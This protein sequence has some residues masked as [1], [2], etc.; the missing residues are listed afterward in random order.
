MISALAPVALA[1]SLLAPPAAPAA[2][3]GA[4]TTG[5]GRDLDAERAEAALAALARDRG[6][7]A[8][9]ALRELDEV[10]EALPDRAQV[11][12]ALAAVAADP[13]ADPE[14]RALARWQQAGHE[15]A[16]GN[17]NKAA[18]LVGRMGFVTRWAVAGPFDDEG[19]RGH[20][21]AYPPEKGLDPAATMAG[22]V[23]E[24]RWRPLAPEAVVDGSVV[25]GAAL[26]PDAEV[27]A[28]ALAVVDAPRELEARLWWGG[29]G[30]ARVWVNGAPVL[31]DA[32]DHPQ[33]LDQRGAVV[34]LAAGPNRI[35]VKQAH[36]PGTWAFSLRLAAAAGEGLPLTV[37]DPAAVLA[38]PPPLPPGPRPAAR[39]IA[40]LV[41]R[42]AAAAEAA[43]RAPGGPGSPARRAEAEARHALAAAMAVRQPFDLQEHRPAREARRATALAPA[44]VEA[45]L[46]AAGLEEERNQRLEHLRAALAAEPANPRVLR[47]LAQIALALDRPQE[48]VRLMEPVV[49]AAPGWVAA[50]LTLATAREAAGQGARATAERL[51]LAE[52]TPATNPAAAA[53]A[54][55]ARRLGRTARAADLYRTALALQVDDG[56]TRGSLASLLLAT[57]DLAGSV[58]LATEALRLDPADQGTR[59]RLAD[60]LAANGRAE[61]A[62][63]AFADALRLCP[64][65]ADAWERRGRV[66]L[67]AGRQAEALADLERALELKPQSPALKELVRSL[68]PRRERYEA[69]YLQDAAALAAA[70]VQAGPEDDL[71]TLSDLE[72]VR[73]QR[74][75]LASRYSQRIVKVLTQRGA[76]A[77]RRQSVGY[78]P[79][80]QEVKVERGRI[81]KPDG[82]AVEAW[83]ESE[84]SASEPWYR[85]YYDTRAK[86]L[87][88]PALAPGDVLE[89]AWRV[90]DTAAENLLS[91]YFGDLAFV[92][93]GEPKRRWDYV[94][95]MPPGRAIHANAPPGLARTDRDLPDGTTEHRWVARD[96]PRLDG[97]PRM[98]GWAEV[99]RFLHVSTY[100]S[101]EEIN[102]FYWGLVQDQLRPTEEVRATARRVAAEALKARGQDPA[103]LEK[104]G[105][106]LDRDTQL[107]L[108]AAMHAFVVTQ[109]RYVG[110]EFGIHGFKPY[111]VDQ[112]LSR[113][114][115]DCKDKASLTHALLESIGIDSRLVLL[116]MRRLGRLPEQPASLAVFNHAILHLPQFGLWLDGTASYTGTREIPGEDR[117]ATVLVVDPGGKPWFGRIG[118][119]GPEENLVETRFEVALAADGAARVEGKS[120][121]A[122]V[123]ASSYRR[124]YQTEN[125]RRAT[126]EQAFNRVYPGVS[127]EQV[128]VGDLTRL[129]EPVAM[130][131]R[132]RAPRFA[133]AGG[134]LLRFTPF[135]AGATYTE[136]WASLSS[137][138]HPLAIGD[139]ATSRFHYRVTLPAGWAVRE[140]PEPASGD[141]PHAAFEVR[142]REEGGAVVTEGFVTLKS[143]QVP[144]ADYPAFR[145]LLLRIDAAFSRRA[146]AGPAAPAA[147]ANQPGAAAAP[148]VQEAR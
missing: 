146:V 126:L 118:E 142:W 116:R 13:A 5:A 45:R 128:A 117:G 98:P 134:G 23:R 84:R 46:L 132:L 111:R 57:G 79:D 48:A 101:W 102:R 11:V 65:D 103:L 120:R 85:L 70:P 86:T 104:G 37:R 58:A 80:R 60:L 30:R 136:T 114:F 21:A 115:G 59:L 138:R 29:S 100:A 1:L 41:E 52:R 113:R 92:D 24:V 35:L 121:I 2:P 76:D 93:E 99:A 73:V 17:L 44:W 18:A 49:A 125:D 16:R 139:P 112:I 130:N 69:P 107:A 15:Q 63:A 42:L 147:A 122:G 32:A 33:R 53:A 66:R 144:P 47:G 26:R 81:I 56:A 9:V 40:G 10:D 34:R 96:V 143:A 75:G 91:D 4:A 88:F 54:G 94:L 12:H 110:L 55:A 19:K 137:R 50:R 74:T 97:E 82:T 14:I 123:Q 6:P 127:T 3:A 140:L 28:Y 43:A 89:V 90:D 31:A 145:E 129:E 131:F 7:R 106:A 68:E 135:G 39:P 67:A 78:T 87:T 27:L 141:G 108:V 148:A 38:A 62:E 119:A 8:V 77:A 105:A 22:K 20:D 83:E 124:A 36:G 133:E 61:E 51:A 64:E 71:V 72:V 25:L 109:T 95:L